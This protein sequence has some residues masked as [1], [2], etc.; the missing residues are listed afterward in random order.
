MGYYNPS[1]VNNIIRDSTIPRYIY[2]IIILAAA[3]LSV[4]FYISI[5][6]SERFGLGV[7]TNKAL[8]TTT[9]TMQKTSKPDINIS[10]MERQL[11]NLINE[12]RGRNGLSF[13]KWND[14]L[15]SIAR[16]HSMDMAKRNYFSH[17]DPEGMDFDYRYEQAGFKCSVPTGGEFLQQGVKTSTKAV[18]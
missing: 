13:L 11:H 10:H 2:F 9:T 12:Q 8:Q 17:K 1:S 5:N 15:S 6:S 3:F 7:K 16:S 4:F 14:E 18:L